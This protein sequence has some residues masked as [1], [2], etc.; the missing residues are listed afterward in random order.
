M[1]N[2]FLTAQY[3]PSEALL[4]KILMQRWGSQCIYHDTIVP[5][6]SSLRCSL[7]CATYLFLVS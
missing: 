1:G 2:R 3:R 4:D 5:I 7:K 6:D